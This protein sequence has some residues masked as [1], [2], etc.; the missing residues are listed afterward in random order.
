[1]LYAIMADIH[2]NLLAFEAVLRDMDGRGKI[3]QVWCLG[4]MVG[5]GPAP[6]QC[7]ERLRQMNHLCVAGNHEW[8][9]TGRIDTFDFNLEAAQ[10]VQWTAGQLT[11]E[12][13]DYIEALPST[14][15]QGPFTMAHGSPRSPLWEYLMDSG[16][17]RENLAYFNTQNCF[18]GHSHIPLFF[19]CGEKEQL[20]QGNRWEAGFPL[21]LG[22]GDRLIINPGS[23]GQPRDGDPRSSYAIYDSEKESVVLVRVRYD[24]EATQRDMERHGLPQQLIRRLSRGV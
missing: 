6:H 16:L 18:I 20:C 5:Y 3:E 12:D 13:R 19:R 15:A 17:A 9:A 14:L 23:V 4:D 24:I 21:K 1:M 7:I 8:A 11:Q 10:A 2:A 22:G